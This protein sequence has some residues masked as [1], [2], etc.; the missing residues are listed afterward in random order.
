M[1][2]ALFLLLIVTAISCRRSGSTTPSVTSSPLS[3]LTGLKYQPEYDSAGKIV[4]QAYAQWSF[5]GTN[6]IIATPA[7]SDTMY[8]GYSKM[9]FTG[10]NATHLV[11]SGALA[12]NSGL[13]MDVVYTTAGTL[14]T[15][16]LT[17][18]QPPTYKKYVF[19]Y[20]GSRIIGVMA[21]YSNMFPDTVQWH[22]AEYYNYIYTGD[23]ISQ[24]ANASRSD[25]LIYNAGSARNN[26][27]GSIPTFLLLEFI[28]LS[29]SG[30]NIG[31]DIPSLVNVNVTESSG[32][33]G[34]LNNF[35]FKTDSI[36]RLTQRIY[37]GFNVTDT[38]FYYY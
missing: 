6:P 19:E 13:I 30:A 11:F 14:D 24:I 29:N 1:K 8:L 37:K 23:N 28:N 32:H 17:Y 18:P 10:A 4:N 16:T 12:F 34:I 36:G 31:Y 38:T 5:S 7:P 26:F 35:T 20:S 33:R 15:I 27:A 2:K 22:E 9:F 21:A 25:T 3:G